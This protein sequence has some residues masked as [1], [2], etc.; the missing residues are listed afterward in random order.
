M[1][2]SMR[3][4]CIALE[5]V[6]LTIKALASRESKPVTIGELAEAAIQKVDEVS[7]NGELELLHRSYTRDPDE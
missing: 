2:G 6:N 1:T 3:D 7:A 4:E 5:S